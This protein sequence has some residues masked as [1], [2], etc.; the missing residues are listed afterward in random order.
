MGVIRA[1]A[2]GYSEGM[3]GCGASHLALWKHA[4]NNQRNIL[5]FEDDAYCRWDLRNQL[6]GLLGNLRDWDVILLGYNTSSVLDVR[7]SEDCNF[8][9]FF[10]TQHTPAQLEK[11]QKTTNNVALMRLNNAFGSCAYL[12]SP[13][14]AEKLIKTFPMDNRPVR[15]PGLQTIKSGRTTFPCVT[16]DAILNTAYRDMNAYAV[17]PPLVI[18]LNDRATSTTIAATDM[19]G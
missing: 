17:V 1:N 2:V 16:S 11:F 7:I 15:V 9:G 8:A 18:P 13:Q 19:I 6:D 5:I 3:I 12:V 4:K 10:S 14:G